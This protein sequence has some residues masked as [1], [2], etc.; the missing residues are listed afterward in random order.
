MGTFPGSGSSD[1]EP[2]YAKCPA[3]L[4][5]YVLLYVSHDCIGPNT[6]IKKSVSNQ[7]SILDRVFFVG[8]RRDLEISYRLCSPRE[9]DD[10]RV[11]GSI[12]PRD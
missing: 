12:E 2:V 7:T 8:C 1:A 3:Q 4:L 5:Q 10:G 9:A 6:V 11:M